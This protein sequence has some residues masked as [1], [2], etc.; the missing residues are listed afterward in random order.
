MSVSLRRNSITPML[1]WPEFAHDFTADSQ[2]FL[3]EAEK[4]RAHEVFEEK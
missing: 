3:E 1:S 4:R 2:A